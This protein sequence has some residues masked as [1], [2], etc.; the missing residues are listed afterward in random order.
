MP[1]P[2]R[3]QEFRLK[4]N[5]PAEKRKRMCMC[6]LNAKEQYDA[7]EREPTQTV[8]Y[9]PVQVIPGFLQLSKLQMNQTSKTASISLYKMR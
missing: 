1:V 9:R 8:Q 3:I 2:V 4:L 7:N 5:R 6:W